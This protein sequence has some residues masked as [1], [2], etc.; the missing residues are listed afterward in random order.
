MFKRYFV[1]RSLWLSHMVFLIR[2]ESS[3]PPLEVVNFT[4]WSR[5]AKPRCFG[6]FGTLESTHEHALSLL[7]KA[8]VDVFE[9]R[10]FN[11]VLLKVNFYFWP[12]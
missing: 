10:L 11:L 12:Y 2:S 1:L 4:W 7:G 6:P 5:P 3:A 9:K 8:S